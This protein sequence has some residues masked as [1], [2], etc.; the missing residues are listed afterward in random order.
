MNLSP[1]LLF[2]GRAQEESDWKGR[3]EIWRKGDMVGRGVGYRLKRESGG[4]ERKIRDRRGERQREAERR[5]R[6]KKDRDT[7]TPTET[8]RE[9]ERHREIPRE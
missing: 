4:E 1:L 7:Q 3:E 9:T 8:Q 6:K 2:W 5:E